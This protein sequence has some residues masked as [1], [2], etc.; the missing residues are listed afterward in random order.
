MKAMGLIGLSVVLVASMAMAE[1]AVKAE[2]PAKA[3]KQDFFKSADTDGDGKLSLDEY[4]AAG[5]GNTEKRFTAADTDKDG[6]LTA[7]ELQ[8]F[9]KAAHEAA[10]AAKAAKAAAAKAAAEAAPAAAPAAEAAPAK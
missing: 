7:D 2:K 4:K 10:K 8:A 3:P 6:F 9:K 1:D 5:K